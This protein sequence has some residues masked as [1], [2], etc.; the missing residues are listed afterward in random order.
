MRP[1]LVVTIVVDNYYID[2]NPDEVV[3]LIVRP[4]EGKITGGGQLE[5]YNSAGVYAAAPDERTNYGFNAMAVKKG[6][7]NIQLK[8]RV[9]V[10][11]RAIDGHKYKIKS[12]A[13]LS[14]G[15]GLGVDPN[16]EPFYAEF[17]SKANLTDVTDSLNPVSLGGNLL[18]QL[19]MT[20]NGEPGEN[21][22][23]SFTLWDGGTC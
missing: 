20:D 16:N 21:D 15:T 4:G 1:P 22:T 3:V 14:L 11:V 12:N 19:R 10:I 6:K 18:L 5:L 23:I 7:K 9:T 17:E 2:T 13:L 8:G